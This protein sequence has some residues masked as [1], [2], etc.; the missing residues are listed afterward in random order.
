M[1]KDKQAYLE[2]IEKYYSHNLSRFDLIHIGITPDIL[3]SYGAEK[4]PIVMQQSTLTKCI[5][6]QT[7]SRS[8][9][10]LSRNIIETVPEQIQNPIFLVQDKERNS[11]VLIT[12]AK[13]KERKNI[14]IAI[15]LN[16]RKGRIIVNE[17]KS[18]YGKNK[19]KEYLLKHISLNQLHVIDNRKAEMLSR[20]VGFQLPQALTA[21][22]YNKNI[23]LKEYK[24]NEK[25]S[26]HDKLKQYKKEIHAKEA[27]EP[28]QQ[29]ES[30]KER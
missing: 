5:R 4:L 22:S 6:M 20:L 3:I 26:V 10:E 25:I 15:K 1:S 24:V 9:H 14:L 11:V 13:D 16:E 23:P 18:I 17:I 27:D 2:Q 21:S 29:K 30:P 12:D 7:G 28:Q 19:L 8:A